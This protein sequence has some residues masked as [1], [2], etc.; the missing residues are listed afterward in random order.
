MRLRT[1]FTLAVM[2][3][4]IL[5]LTAISASAS[6]TKKA[7]LPENLV[8]M[9]VQVIAIQLDDDHQTGIHWPTAL[10]EFK[11]APHFSSILVYDLRRLMDQL[12]QAGE[13]VLLY[14]ERM[15]TVCN[16]SAN[17][18]TIETVSMMETRIY[19]G[20]PVEAVIKHETGISLKFNVRIKEDAEEW[21]SIDY[22]LNLA[23]PTSY[24]LVNMEHRASTIVQDHNSIIIDKVF[25]PNEPMIQPALKAGETK[26][27]VTDET[28]AEIQQSPAVQN[29]VQ[30]VT[31]ITPHIIGGPDF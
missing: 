31:L 13:P 16:T 9:E 27:T 11:T 23:L 8:E 5:S 29:P 22:A 1:M 7:A 30:I 26:I 20:K 18:K 12:S 4:F 19:E 25:K 21:L 6:Q 15:S 2:G 3:V 28:G 17:I 10:K 24:G 14:N